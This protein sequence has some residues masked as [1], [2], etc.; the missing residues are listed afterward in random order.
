MFSGKRQFVCSITFMSRCAREKTKALEHLLSHPDHQKAFFMNKITLRDGINGVDVM[1]FT[2]APYKPG[3]P[4][5]PTSGS[6]G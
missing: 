4:M 2:T 3:K 5:W 6:L 1:T